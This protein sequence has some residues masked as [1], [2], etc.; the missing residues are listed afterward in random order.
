MTCGVHVSQGRGPGGRG[1]ERNQGSPRRSIGERSTAA[2]GKESG[3]R[4]C[5]TQPPGSPPPCRGEPCAPPR[6]QPALQGP[7]PPEVPLGAHQSCL[8]LSLCLSAIGTSFL[9][10]ENSTRVNLSA[11]FLLS[12]HSI[13]ICRPSD[14]PSV[15]FSRQEQGSGW[16]FP[17][18]G[19]R[20][21]PGI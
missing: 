12:Q 3:V 7:R 15:E 18:P 1:K 20:P 9:S 14:S 4:S 6:P 11:N 8:F 2:A 17:F 10:S 19:N 5:S 16:P 13:C 21:D